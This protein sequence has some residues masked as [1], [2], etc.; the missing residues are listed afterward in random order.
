MKKLILLTTILALVFAWGC[1][2]PPVPTGELTVTGPIG[3]DVG[4]GVPWFTAWEDLSKRGYVEEEFFFE[5]DATYYQLDGRMTSNGKWNVSPKQQTPFKSRL[6]VRRPADPS[7]FNGTVI[8]EWFNVSGGIDAAP[9]W[10]FL[11]PFLTREGYIWVGVSAQKQGVSGK[12]MGAIQPMVTYDPERYGSLVHPGDAYSYDIYTQAARVIKGQGSQEVLGGLKAKRLL[13]YGESQSAFTMITYTN[14]IQPIANVFD[15]L[16]IHSRSAVGIPLEGQWGTKNQTGFEEAA[17]SEEEGGC[18]SASGKMNLSVKVRTDI[19]V[20]VFQFETETDVTG[21]YTARQ[22]DTKF[23]RTWEVPGTAHADF[24][25]AS[26]ITNAENKDAIPDGAEMFTCETGNKGPHYI[27]LRAALK[28]LDNWV[29][30]GTQPPKAEP[31]AMEG[32][33]ILKDEF[34]NA[35]GGVRTPNVDVPTSNL[36]PMPVFAGNAAAE[37]VTT[38][39]AGG[40]CENLMGVACAVFG[41]TVPFTTEQLQALYPTHEDYVTKF[42]ASAEATVKAGF[43]LREE[44]DAI[45][46]K[47]EESPIPAAYADVW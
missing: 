21:F 25:L 36:R 33:K 1:E 34:D 41:A 14:A 30:D 11:E 16:F 35:L 7:K 31:L 45:I 12:G 10:M 18:G 44:A 20:P 38:S 17:E 26:A 8:V 43:M 22:P 40:G 9:A 23:I 3:S 29:K 15:G 4:K 6:L 32:N 46:K 2:E 27:T 24:Y 5:G 37:E 39:A 13:A 47:A 28:A 19:K 42:K